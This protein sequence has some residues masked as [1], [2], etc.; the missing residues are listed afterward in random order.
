MN[1]TTTPC[2][3]CGSPVS[4]FE[5]YC[6]NCGAPAPTPDDAS[7][8]GLSQEDQ[9][10]TLD[11]HEPLDRTPEA[12]EESAIEAAVSSTPSE[13]SV[14]TPEPEPEPEPQGYLI[15][16]SPEVLAA[17]E[18]AASLEGMTIEKFINVL[19]LPAAKKILKNKKGLLT[20]DQAADRLGITKA[21]VVKLISSGQLRAKKVDGE[22]KVQEESLKQT[23]SAT[24]A[25]DDQ[26]ELDLRSLAETS[27]LMGVDFDTD[28]G[29]GGNV[30]ATVCYVNQAGELVF[31]RA[32][33]RKLGRERVVSEARD[34]VRRYLRRRDREMGRL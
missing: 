23:E 10:D 5:I 15:D 3:N 16:W 14:V 27:G 18:E 7:M 13:E 11:G 24:T 29:L 6:P 8:N 30:S 34:A 9:R 31:P 20:L 26:I 22:W 25:G 2:T 32:A 28:L 1:E 17:V 19:V 4:S 33:W 21:E 12:P